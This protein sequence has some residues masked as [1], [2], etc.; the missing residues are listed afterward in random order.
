MVLNAE[1]IREEFAKF[2][3]KYDISD[4]LNAFLSEREKYLNGDKTASGMMKVHFN[5]LYTSLKCE[6]REGSLKWNEL[7]YLMDLAGKL[8]D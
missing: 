7:T 8:E 2:K 4:E 3:F 6:T 5:T 1:Q